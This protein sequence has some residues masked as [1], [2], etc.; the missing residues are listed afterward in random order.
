MRCVRMMIPVLA[1]A[2]TAS[3]AHADDVVTLKT[4]EALHGTVV[5]QADGVVTFKHPVLGQLKIKSD[6]VATVMTAEQ[7]A[8]KEAA[9][10]QAK[11]QE[12]AAAKLKAEKAGFFP[13][14]D[15]QLEAG[16]SGAEGNTEELNLYLRF[17]TKHE[18]DDT[19]TKI[20]ARY[21]LSTQNGDRNESEAQAGITKDWFINDS[22]WF[23]F[24]DATGDY[25]E[26][27][28]W[29]YRAAGHVGL[30]YQLVRNEKF[31]WSVRG[32]I[33]AIKEFNSPNDDVRPEALA[34]TDLSWKINDRQTLNFSNYIYPDLD[35]TGEFRNVTTA[36]WAIKIDNVDNLSLKFGLANEYE[37]NAPSDTDKNDLKYFGALVWGF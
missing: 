18:T 3:V 16:F 17:A 34:G 35:E 23:I 26:F 36:D 29:E 5:N 8:A 27:E 21:F 19:R 37:S 22:P 32:G 20:H 6:Q 14:W 15:S 4:G 10:A 11:A 12:E 25:D 33:G 24:A 13:G 2:L 30:G 31:D 9:A 1:I 28:S 7:I